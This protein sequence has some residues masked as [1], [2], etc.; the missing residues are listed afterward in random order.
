MMNDDEPTREEED[1]WAAQLREQVG[2]YLARQGVKHGQIGDFPA[3]HV[4]PYVSIWAIESARKPGWVGWW[5]IAGDV[6]TDYATCSGDRTPRTAVRDFGDRWL[7]ASE[8]M[9]AGRE[10]QDVAF[11]DRSQWPKLAPLLRGRASFLLEV[12]A[13]DEEW[14][15]MDEID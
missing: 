12:A 1:R 6:P 15:W 5:A 10:P 4:Y 8:A 7:A 13:D 14:A 9:F 11:G 2:A 3:W